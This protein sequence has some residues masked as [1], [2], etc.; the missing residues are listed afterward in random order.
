[1]SRGGTNRQPTGI[2]AHSG[3]NISIYVEA[4]DNDPLP[5]I[6][7]TQY[8]G[9]YS[10]WMGKKIQLKKGKN[11]LTVDNFDIIDIKINILLKNKAKI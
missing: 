11:I 7:F 2:F 9:I 3:E 4:E 5:N 8:I 10:K 6:I 1:M